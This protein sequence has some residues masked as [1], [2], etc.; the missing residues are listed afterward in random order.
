M[1]AWCIPTQ[2]ILSPCC[3]SP[4]RKLISE[5][6][7]S[8]S[9]LALEFSQGSSYELRVRA[10]PQPGSSFQ[11]T[12]SEWSN[13]VIFRIQ[14]DGKGEDEVDT[15]LLVPNLALVQRPRA[16]RCLSWLEGIHS[17]VYPLW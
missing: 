2:C 6:S 5:D 17:V 16:L 3:Q 1:L 4:G 10:G 12:W 7:R 9:L 14:L 11:G 8:V 15:S 13:P